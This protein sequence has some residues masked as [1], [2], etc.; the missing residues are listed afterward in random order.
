MLRYILT[1]ACWEWDWNSKHIHLLLITIIVRYFNE[2]VTEICF[3][4]V[5]FWQ[6]SI[7]KSVDINGHQLMIVKSFLRLLRRELEIYWGKKEPSCVYRAIIPLNSIGNNTKIVESEKRVRGRE[8]EREWGRQG[9][10]IKKV[11]WE[12]TTSNESI[13]INIIAPTTIIS[14]TQQTKRM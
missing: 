4:W 7:N 10:R 13:E 5:A 6:G 9:K 14:S 11:K 3:K 1:R 8:R 12:A 2:I